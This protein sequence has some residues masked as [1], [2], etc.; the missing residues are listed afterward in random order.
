MNIKPCP[1]CNSEAVL[2][3][4]PDQSDYC[5]EKTT[6]KL[7]EYYDI[8]CTNPD[9]YLCDGA[10]WNQSRPED[11]IEIW[12]KRNKKEYRDRILND[13]GI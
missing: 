1:F 10:D 2:K 9:C 13:L 8:M 7:K 12:N 6:G 5:F 3:A 4:I 11:I